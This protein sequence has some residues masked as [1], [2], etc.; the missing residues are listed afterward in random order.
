[1]DII[2]LIGGLFTLVAAVIWPATILTVILVLR[3]G[4]RKNRQ[5]EDAK[6]AAGNARAAA[7]LAQVRSHS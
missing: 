4:V 6:V 3:H 2:T 7:L 1:M 5:E